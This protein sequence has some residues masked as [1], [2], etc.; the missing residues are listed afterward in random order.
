MGE[1]VPLNPPFSDK[2]RD[3]LIVFL[4]DSHQ[5]M[6]ER[7][8]VLERQVIED[9]QN[10]VRLDER[11]QRNE[12]AL[13]KVLDSLRDINTA[14]SETRDVVG[15]WKAAQGT[16]KTLSSVGN[17]IK[18]AAGVAAAIAAAWALLT[19]EVPGQ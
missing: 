17:G 9:A 3:E 1:A 14:T 12:A 13:D 16:V 7:V 15:A 2:R 10:W 19:G 11:G 6:H 8:S 18:W 4:I 5:I